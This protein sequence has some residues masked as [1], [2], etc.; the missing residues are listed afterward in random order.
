MSEPHTSLPPVSTAKELEAYFSAAATPREGW[1][2][3]VEQEK[4]A[5]R[6]NGAPVPYY[7]PDGIAELLTRLGARGW[8]PIA[9][10]ER[11]IGLSRGAEQVT[12]EPGMQVELSGPALTTALACRE[13]TRGHVVEL[14]ELARPLD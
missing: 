6:S 14:A 10:G 3:G 2:V 7:G 13:V 12:L 11:L 1:L 8:S 9:E 5:V 4:I